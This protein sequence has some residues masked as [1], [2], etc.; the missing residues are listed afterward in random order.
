MPVSIN[1]LAEAQALE[2]L[3]RRD[4]VKRSIWV[5]AFLLIAMLAVSSWLQLQVIIR[6]GELGRVE[7]QITARTTEFQQVL[8]NQKKLTDYNHRLASLQNL[9]TNRLLY[10]TLLNAL[11]KSTVD[12]VQL[13][14]FRTDQSFVP[15]S[16]CG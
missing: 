7:G 6:K 4:P 1:L 11:Q 12:D 3:R 10:G 16:S 2:E 13:T 5:A 8:Q 14:R 9:A 15:N